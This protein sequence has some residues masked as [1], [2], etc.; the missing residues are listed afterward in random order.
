MRS[1]LVF[2]ALAPLALALNCLTVQAESA[3]P[4]PP[5]L[6]MSDEGLRER[7]EHLLQMHALSDRILAA[8]DPKEKEKLKEEQLQLMKSYELKHHQMMQRHMKEMMD[9]KPKP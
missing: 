9:K 1:P 5:G 8:K 3:P 2:G 4:P 7:Q 6:M